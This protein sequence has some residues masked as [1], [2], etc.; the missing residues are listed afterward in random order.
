[1]IRKCKICK[2]DFYA[3]PNRVKKGLSKF[4]SKYCFTKSRK[5]KKLPQWW[6][7]KLKLNRR[8][9]NGYKNS[10]WK[11]KKVGSPGIHAWLR[12]KYGNADRCEDSTC[13][14]K[15]KKYNWALRKGY[16]YERKRK[17]F[18]R[19]C[20]SCHRNLDYTKEWKR[21]LVIAQ[22]KRHETH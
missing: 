2:K 15:S 5:D 16:K 20:I 1:M 8:N 12:T 4:C 10:M 7:D 11:G 17:N 14:G 6:K 9:Q 19:L 21:N 18:I 3:K 13:N 22:R